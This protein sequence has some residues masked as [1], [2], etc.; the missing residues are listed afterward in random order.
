MISPLYRYENNGE[1]FSIDV[2]VTFGRC[3]ANKRLK[4]SEL[5]VMLTDAAGADFNARGM[6]HEYLNEHDVAFLVSRMSVHFL[7]DITQGRQITIRTWENASKGS[8]FLRCFE[9]S[10]IGGDI[11]ATA[12]T[13]WATVVPSTRRILRPTDLRFEGRSIVDR[14]VDCMPCD[15][16]RLPSGGL[17]PLGKH[18]VVFSDLDGNGHVNNSRYSAFAFDAL[19]KDMQ[20][21]TLRD[22][23]INYAHE[24]VQGDDIELSGGAVEFTGKNE[25]SRGGYMVAGSH[26][27]G[28]CFNCELYF[29]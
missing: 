25:K 26:E 11:L 4:L 15:K 22:F 21:R 13:S 20:G 27:R 7:K 1:T 17:V 14:T 2:L 24:A 8:Q 10:D 3:D 9:I 16:L 23:R 18:E 29:D 19:S 28:Q 6:S 5:M 12:I